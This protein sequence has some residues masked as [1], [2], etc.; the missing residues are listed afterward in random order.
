MFPKDQPL[1]FEEPAPIRVSVAQ[2]SA[3]SVLVVAYLAFAATL[4]GYSLWDRLLTR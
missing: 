3:V 1:A 2:I 4:L